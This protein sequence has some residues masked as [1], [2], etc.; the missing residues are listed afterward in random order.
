MHADLVLQA[1]ETVAVVVGVVF[2]LIQLRQLRFQREI[3]AGIELLH[4]LQA[5]QMAEAV[6]MI[7]L[8][9]D[10]LTGEQL[11]R[12]LG[13]SFGCVMG[14]LAESLGPIIA[15][16]HVPIDM[17]AD[18]YRRV[19]VICRKKMQ[20]YI[21]E[22]RRQGWHNLFEWLQW[23]AERME[24]RGDLASDIPAFERFRKWKSGADYERLCAR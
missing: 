21:E 22:R 18:S 24:E 14:V 20:P 11:H 6:M 3:Q 8:L 19:T 4:P 7:H 9:P 13:D 12:K 1:I 17:Y 5:P 10:G 23:L 16:G 15:R 2:G